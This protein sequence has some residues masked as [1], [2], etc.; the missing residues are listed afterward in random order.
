MSF[1]FLPLD[2]AL[3]VEL[4]VAGGN[5]RRPPLERLAAHGAVVLHFGQGL[6]GDRPKSPGKLVRHTTRFLKS[7]AS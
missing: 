6:L 4:V 2:Q 3:L 5:G 1:H 7:E